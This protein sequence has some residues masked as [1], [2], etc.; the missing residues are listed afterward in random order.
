[1][2]S[3]NARRFA[4]QPIHL[5]AQIGQFLSHFV[6]RRFHFGAALFGRL[7]FMRQRREQSFQ[8]FL[9]QIRP[10]RLSAVVQHARVVGDV[11]AE[12]AE[13]AQDRIHRL[14][15]RFTQAVDFRARL[16]HVVLFV[17]PAAQ[18][19]GELH[20]VLDAP[21]EFAAQFR[22]SFADEVE[23]HRVVL[24]NGRDA[25]PRHHRQDFPQD[26]N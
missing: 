14:A 20:T 18:R 5:C 3:S 13:F 15:H 2:P 11:G 1:M 26:L 25:L 23:P 24:R 21:V 22:V 7:R 19:R 6:Q 16:V 4:R 17:K 9:R 8:V 10:E 12:V